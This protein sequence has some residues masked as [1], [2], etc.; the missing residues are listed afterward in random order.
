[1]NRRFAPDCVY[2]SCRGKLAH[3]GLVE[4]IAYSVQRCS[5]ANSQNTRGRRERKNQFRGG[6]RAEAKAAESDGVKG[7]VSFNA[8]TIMPL[9]IF[10]IEEERE[11]ESWSSRRPIG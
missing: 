5:N 2:G 8:I 9:S 7:Q 6:G 1:M 11:R 3:N 10:P 4:S